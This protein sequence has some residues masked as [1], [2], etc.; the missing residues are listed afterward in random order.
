MLGSV[1][2][3]EEVI[4]N[5]VFGAIRE[6]NP[7]V[8][9]TWSIYMVS[10]HDQYAY[11]GVSFRIYMWLLNLYVWHD[12]L[13]ARLVYV[14]THQHTYQYLTDIFTMVSDLETPSA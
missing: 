2:V 4:H 6:A 1:V 5:F 3:V 14:A 9:H 8:D 13:A 12:L 10:L 11:M 7:S